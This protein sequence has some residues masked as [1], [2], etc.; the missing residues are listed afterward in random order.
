MKVKGLKKDSDMFEIEKKNHTILGSIEN[1][2]CTG[3]LDW[4]V[5]S[6]SAAKMQFHFSCHMVEQ[7]AGAA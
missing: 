2:L 6:V 7:I 4:N 5:V 1:Y 3:S